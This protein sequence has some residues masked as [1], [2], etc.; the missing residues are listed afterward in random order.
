M[1]S[2]L[3]SFLWSSSRKWR[4]VAYIDVSFLPPTQTKSRLI[5]EAEIAVDN[6]Y[7]LPDILAGKK[8]SQL[9]SSQFPTSIVAHWSQHS[10]TIVLG[11]IA[12]YFFLFLIPSPLGPTRKQ[13]LEF[14]P[15]TI[16]IIENLSRIPALFYSV[17]INHIQF[18][19]FA[20]DDFSR[21]D[22]PA[23]LVR[24][25]QSTLNSSPDFSSSISNIST[26]VS[27]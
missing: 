13:T 14:P 15:A 9:F 7:F 1:W 21:T 27:C 24:T 6:F 5:D 19:P 12:I 4:L 26:I 20:M 3:E 8:R 22:Y 10:S 23:M 2:V 18:F 25:A 16:R 11:C 17:R